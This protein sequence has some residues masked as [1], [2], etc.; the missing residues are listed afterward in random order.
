MMSELTDWIDR[1]PGPQ[2]IEDLVEQLEGIAEEL[3]Q[4]EDRGNHAEVCRRTRMKLLWAA[5][6]LAEVEELGDEE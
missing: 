4:H 6:L 2:S 5:D 3:G 1:S